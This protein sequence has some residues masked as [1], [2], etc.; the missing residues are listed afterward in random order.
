M[1]NLLTAAIATNSAPSGATAG[2]ALNSRG[3][4]RMAEEYIVLVDFAGTGAQSLTLKAW[5]WSDKNA[6][7]YPLGTL[8]DGSAITGTTSVTYAEVLYS[9]K[10]FDRVYLEITAISGTSNTVNAQLCTRG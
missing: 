9:L 1:L 10:H 7:W 2:Q 6:K 8:N 3:G 4:V 5:G